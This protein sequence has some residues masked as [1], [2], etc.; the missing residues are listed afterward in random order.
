MQEI[1]DKIKNKEELDSDEIECLFYIDGL[2]VEEIEINSDMETA[3]IETII[4]IEDKYYCIEWERALTEYQ[5]DE[6]PSQVL[7][8]VKPYEEVLIS[9]RKVK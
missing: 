7:T 6:Y 3:E 1:F 9:W 5:E 4:K 8:E 2:V